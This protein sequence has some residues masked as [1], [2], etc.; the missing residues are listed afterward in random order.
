MRQSGRKVKLTHRGASTLLPAAAILMLWNVP[1][2]FLIGI[3]FTTFISWIRFPDRVADGGLVRES[4][5]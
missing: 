3:L 2:S 1:G 5:G 4:N